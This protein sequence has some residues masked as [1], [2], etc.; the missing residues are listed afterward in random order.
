LKVVTDI[1][2]QAVISE[3]VANPDCQYCTVAWK[4]DLGKPI[5]A[6]TLDD[7]FNDPDKAYNSFLA[8]YVFTILIEALIGWIIFLVFSKKISFSL[9]TWLPA[10]LVANLLAYPISWLVIPSFG[11]FQAEMIRKTAIMV[12]V[13]VAVVTTIALILRWRKIP[14]KKGMMIALAIAV[15]VCVVLFMIGLLAVSYGSYTVHVAGLPWTTVV[16]LAESFAVIFETIFIW[17]FLKKEQKLLWVAVFVI[18]MNAS[19]LLLGLLV[20]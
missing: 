17:L 18:I 11:Q 19:S 20:F 15:P 5:P 6:V 12:I 14:V 8:A 9:R 4:I 7:D 13:S 16:I 3:P 10:V 2:D 1:A